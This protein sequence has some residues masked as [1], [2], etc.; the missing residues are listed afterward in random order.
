[1]LCAYGAGIN[2][3]FWDVDDKLRDVSIDDSWFVGDIFGAM[4]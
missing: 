1:M 2:E 4:I 3:I